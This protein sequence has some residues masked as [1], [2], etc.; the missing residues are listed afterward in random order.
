M[1]DIG[2]IKATNAAKPMFSL[3]GVN[4]YVKNKLPSNIKIPELKKEIESTIPHQLFIG[5]RGIFIGDF[6]YLETRGATAIS[7]N[8]SIFLTNKQESVDDIV[9]DIAH[10]IGHFIEKKFFFNIHKN[11]SLEKEFL[12]KK[13]YSLA[14]L[15]RT[16]ANV[17]LFD[18]NTSHDEE[19]D[20]I[21]TNHIGLHNLEKILS[22]VLVT[23]YSM[24]SLSEYFCEGLEYYLLN[25]RF[26]LAKIC[27]V[28]YNVIDTIVTEGY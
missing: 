9:D 3:S 1:S 22:G 28:L 21:I 16:G 19:V 26:F 5:I 24:V 10:E 23:P 2:Y 14:L 11:Q 6:E 25:D 17:D 15:K 7:Y 20:N 13:K 18:I 27:P 8:D 4:V 12:S